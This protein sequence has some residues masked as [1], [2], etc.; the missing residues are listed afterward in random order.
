M[1]LIARINQHITFTIHPNAHLIAP[2]TPQDMACDTFLKI[3][4]KCKRKFVVLQLQES[5][6]FIAE[7]LDGLAATIQDLQPHQIHTFYESV[8]LMIGAE[9]GLA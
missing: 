5:Q 1:D 2:T 3:C 7:L 8:G 6:P 4:N 9:G